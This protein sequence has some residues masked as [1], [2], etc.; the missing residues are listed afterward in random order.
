LEEYTNGEIILGNSLLVH[1]MNIRNKLTLTVFVLAV[2]PVAFSFIFTIPNNAESNISEVLLHLS[3]VANIH[4]DRLLEL[5]DDYYGELEYMA[6]YQIPD[7]LEEYLENSSID[8]Q[9]LIYPILQGAQTRNQ[10]VEQIEVVDSSGTVLASTNITRIGVDISSLDYFTNNLTSAY[11]NDFYLTENNSLAV[12]MKE[13]VIV[14][15]LNSALIVMDYY[16]SDLTELFKDYEGLGTTGEALLA[17][18]DSSGDAM[19]V[20]PLRHLTGASLNL[21]LSKDNLDAPITQA[22]LGIESTFENAIDYRDHHVLAAT[23]YLSEVDWGIVVKMD[24]TEAY[25]PIVNSF[26]ATAIM[27]IISSI[28]V[29]VIGILVS[30]SITTPISELSETARKISQGDFSQ[31]SNVTSG[32]EIELL[33][34]LINNMADILVNANLELERRVKKRTQ[35]LAISNADLEQ[36]AF[37]ISHDLQ[38]PLRMVVSYLQ[39]IEDRFSDAIDEDLHEFIDYAVD[40]AKRMREMI[41][42][43]LEYSRVGRAKEFEEVDCNGIVSYVLKNLQVQL[44]ESGGKVEVGTLPTIIANRRGIIALFQNLLSNAIKFRGEEQLV[45]RIRLVEHE[46]DWLFSI[47]DNGIGIPNKYQERIFDVFYR[48]H[49]MKKYDGTGIGLSI[50]KKVIENL[51]G[52]I[53]VESEQNKGSTFYFT[54]S[55]KLKIHE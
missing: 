31:R 14:D 53:W 10:L 39:L 13:P 52:R 9:D 22:L 29:I 41:T 36:F 37:V 15:G 16:L 6:N 11:L 45:I 46:N 7:F 42:S 34:N 5:V 55:K 38:E 25:A 23:R 35:E 18:R 33:G 12:H 2:L 1:A 19:F 28:A 44:D 40:G 47:S 30:E 51:S 20:T 43:L 24:L 54:I 48:L 27:S 50:C 8:L 17:K 26:N 49:S 21:T 4:K 3:S 32:D